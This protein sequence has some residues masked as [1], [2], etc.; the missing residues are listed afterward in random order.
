MATSTTYLHTKAIPQLKELLTNYGDFPVVIWFDTPT[1]NM[2]PERLRERS[3]PC[4][5]SIPT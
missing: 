4:S 3:S 1:A 5:T 2:T